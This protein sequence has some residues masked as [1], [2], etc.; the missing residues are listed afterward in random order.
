MRQIGAELGPLKSERAPFRSGE[1]HGTC[2][3]AVLNNYIKRA[4]LL[5]KLVLMFCIEYG[6]FLGR[7]SSEIYG[8]LCKQMN[9]AD[10]LR[11]DDNPAESIKNNHH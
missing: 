6:L 2:R 8:P 5:C 11:M 10:Q 4:Y 9:P 3:Y 1:G 7:Y